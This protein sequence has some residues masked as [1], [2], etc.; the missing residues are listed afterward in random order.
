MTHFIQATNETRRSQSGSDA[1]LALITGASGGVGGSCA[2]AL[3]EIGYATLVVGRR[4]EELRTVTD[5]INLRFGDSRP[6]TGF[7][8]D[9]A[10]REDI[11]ALLARVESLKAPEIF[12]SAAGVTS[13]STARFDDDE[14][15][16]VMAIN[17]LAPIYLAR[18]I[19]GL[20]EKADK[21][22]IINIASR[23]GIQGFS[24]KGLYGASKAATIRYFDALYA[25]NLNT[26][27]RVTSI[28]P[29][30]INTRMATAGGCRKEPD[31]ILQPDDISTAI[32]WL[33]SSPSRIR[34][35]ELVV[36]AGGRVEAAA[37]A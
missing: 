31:E 27:I 30:W 19:V 15:D 33:V 37:Q 1:P 35:R 2:K 5:D 23:A 24:D 16:E 34:I 17:A 18:G 6:C 12:I 14:L 8:A 20:M 10:K 29:G 25:G 21:G 11:K 22:Y 13:N 3:A 26:N 36:E 32:V 28:C 7:Q 9:L 4:A